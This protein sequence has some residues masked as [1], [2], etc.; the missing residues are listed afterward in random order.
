MSLQPVQA[1]GCADAFL[2]PE[3]EVQGQYETVIATGEA[4]AQLP[5]VAH[6]C[7]TIGHISLVTLS[8]IWPKG[9]QTH[10][11]FVQIRQICIRRA[12]TVN[13]GFAIFGRTNGGFRAN[14]C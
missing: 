9:R 2:L 11:E 12:R 5:A 10:R 6:Q 4:G 1:R 14:D 8:C 13:C 7:N 3:L